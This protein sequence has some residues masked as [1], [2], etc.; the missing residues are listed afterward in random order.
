MFKHIIFDL[1]NTIYN[2]DLAHK[3]AL[4]LL[5]K[6]MKTEFKIHN[7]GDVFLKEKDKFKYCCGNNASCHNKFIQLK[8]TFEILN[9]DFSKLH[10]FY[11]I[12]NN[13]FNQ[14][15]QL[16]PNVLEFL[17]LCKSKNIKLYILTNNLCQIQIQ[18]LSKLGILNFFDKIYTSEEFG[19]EKPDIKLIYFIMAD[20]GCSK[21]EIL[22]IGDSYKNDIE[23]LITYD[24]YSFWFHNTFS[25]KK[26]YLEFGKYQ[27]II[28]FFREYFINLDN[29]IEISR[30]VGERFDLVQAGGGNT[31]FKIN[32]LVFVKSSGCN[33]TSLDVNKNY[34]GLDFNEIKRNLKNINNKDKK[35]REVNSKKIV[36]ENIIFLKN[37]KP[38]IETTLHCLTLKYTVHI[39]PI[40]FNYI[41]SLEDC[42]KIL[43]KIF[44][45]YILIDYFTPGIDVALN[46]KEKY[47][48]QK[49]IFMKN[50][51]IVVTSDNIDDLK[52][53]LKDTI[54]KL[55]LELKLNFKK[56][57]FVNEISEKMNLIFGGKRVTYLCEND[58]INTYIK[59]ET[60]LKETF[61]TF[62]PDKLV[63]CGKSFVLI[64]KLEE[65]INKCFLKE[66]EQPKI[67]ILINDNPCLYICS[68]NLNKCRE[69]EQVLLSHIL[70]YNPN[71]IFLEKS[72]LDYLNNWDA[73]K[74]RKIL[75]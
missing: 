54:D 61:K 29:F 69:I 10:D 37:Y 62:F 53:I 42:S 17:E 74:F 73:E 48:N 63:Y 35:V 7:V 28:N 20:I 50:H 64:K 36:D 45:N 5:F 19:I 71:N 30:Y 67:F 16:Y 4:E 75:N 2:Y 6:K 34:V 51:G 56:Y 12:Y 23:N 58:Y 22:K 24:I 27:E 14:N 31:S 60:N 68:T 55:E 8:K 43:E 32:N 66:N 33:L 40:Q 11:D 38:S 70:C 13:N 21:N 49:L 47:K 52:N 39:H 26:K 3:K 57:K 15:L 65:D 72:E 9:L 18:K 25:L 59:N 46:L 41:S 44:D 1:D